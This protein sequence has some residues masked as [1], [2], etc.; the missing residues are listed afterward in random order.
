MCLFEAIIVIIRS[1]FGWGRGDYNRKCERRTRRK[2]V[3]QQHIDLKTIQLIE[4]QLEAGI[5]LDLDLKANKKVLIRPMIYKIISMWAYIELLTIS[6]VF[7]FA[8]YDHFPINFLNDIC[9]KFEENV[10]KRLMA[11]VI[12]FKLISA[13]LLLLGAK[14]VSFVFMF[15]SSILVLFH[16]YILI[17]FV[18]IFG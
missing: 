6:F 16:I 13:V 14:T 10:C 7:L 5:N 17:A 8:S 11:R 1:T 9:D 15:L 2:I 18:T 12:C 3:R 4:S